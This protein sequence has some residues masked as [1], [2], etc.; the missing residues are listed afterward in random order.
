MTDADGCRISTRHARLSVM[1]DKLYSFFF[2]NDSVFIANRIKFT[3]GGKSWHTLFTDGQALYY[4]EPIGSNVRLRNV[5]FDFGFLPM[6]KYEESQE[7]YITPISQYT[8]TMHVSVV[9]DNTA[10]ISVVLE[11]LCAESY[12]SVRPIYFDQII[13]GKRIQDD[14]TIEMF[15][16]I[17]SKSGDELRLRLR[18]GRADLDNEQLRVK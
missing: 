15:D 7:S 14:S 8:H 2:V 5:S 1:F 12:C 3:E 17:F 9:N 13:A 16:I 18:L 4:Y 6:P 11:N 10:M